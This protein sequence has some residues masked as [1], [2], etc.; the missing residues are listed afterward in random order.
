LLLEGRIYNSNILDDLDA[1]VPQNPNASVVQA[2]QLEGL[3][4]L[5]HLS[6]VVVD[7]LVLGEF[8]RTA[9]ALST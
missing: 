4:L 2:L 1:E 6:F 9:I 3:V 5:L 8:L 7:R